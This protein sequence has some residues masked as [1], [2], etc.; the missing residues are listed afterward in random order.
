MQEDDLRHRYTP[1]EG[2][3][4]LR[5]ARSTLLFASRVCWKIPWLAAAA[6]HDLRGVS[7][8]RNSE[9]NEVLRGDS[10]DIRLRIHEHLAVRGA[11]AIIT[12]YEI[13]KAVPAAIDS[14]C[15]WTGP[16]R[17][18]LNV[19]QYECMGTHGWDFQYKASRRL[20]RD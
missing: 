19:I 11:T 17:K 9:D 1:R 10:G 13:A 8:V 14:F 3:L 5:P 16:R 20:L 15:V 2:K 12:S 18:S 6:H 7:L 4:A